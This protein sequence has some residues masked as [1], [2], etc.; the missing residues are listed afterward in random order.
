MDLTHDAPIELDRQRLQALD[1]LEELPEHLLGPVTLADGGM[2]MMRNPITKFPG[3]YSGRVNDQSDLGIVW[4]VSAI[5]E[6]LEST[7]S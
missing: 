6:I 3:I 1:L 5:A 4:K 7:N 2:Q